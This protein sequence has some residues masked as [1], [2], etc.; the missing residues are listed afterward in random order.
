[1]IFVDTG[2]FFAAFVPSDPDHVAAYGWVMENRQPLV[3]SDYILDELLTLLKARGEFQRAL[4]LGGKL[5]SGETARLEWVTPADVQAAWQIF[6]T[7][8]DKGWSFTD[9]VSLAMMRRLHISVA[10]AFDVHFRQFG[11]IGVV[12]T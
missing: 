9:C 5:L 6:S 4:D 7:F 11:E 10:F 3:T 1:V 8:R 2:A 12:P